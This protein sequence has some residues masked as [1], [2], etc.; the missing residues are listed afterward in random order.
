MRKKT[1]AFCNLYEELNRENRLFELSDAPIGDDLLLPFGELGRKAE[2][3]GVTVATTA[4]LLPEQ[5]DAY[6]LVD[7]PDPESPQFRM[8]RASGRPLYL[9]M[10]ESPLA[11]P[12]NYDSL[13]HSY[14]SRVFTYNDSLVDGQKF[15]K[16]NYSY[17]LPSHVN[18]DLQRKTKL[19]V[20]IAGNKM[21]SHPQE[22]YS[23]RRAAIRWFEYHH[24]DDFDLF[25][26]GWDKIQSTKFPKLSLFNR[27]RFLKR[28]FG[29]SFPSWRGAVD[30][31]RDVMGNYRF[32]LCYENIRDIPGYIT[33]KI[34]DAFFA[35]TVPVYRG[36]S[37]ITDHI[38]ENCFIDL[39]NFNG[40][41]DLYRYL[42]GLSDECYLRYLNAI[43][44]FLTSES[45]KVFSCEYFADTILME[46]LN[47]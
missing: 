10:L 17:S 29:E 18:H 42:S 32:A 37:N 25:G 4:V 40:Y 16:I 24:P 30:R 46:I 14:F 31:K 28:F 36:A 7:M 38:P 43:E 27:V 44:D 19:C 1:I 23:E 34:F 20:T 2:C 21:S 9:L 39:R 3:L 26:T 13:N 5:I 22:L 15:I 8:A 33:E 35:G 41:A 45:A 6:V 11:V 12:R 47:D